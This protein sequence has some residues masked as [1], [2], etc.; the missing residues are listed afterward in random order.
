MSTL[1]DLFS[2]SLKKRSSAKAAK[3]ASEAVS[4]AEAAARRFTRF[5]A[6]RTENLKDQIAEK[7][8]QAVR[9]LPLLLHVNQEGLPGYMPDKLCPFGVT[10]FDPKEADLA[11]A[12]TLFPHS[13]LKRAAAPRMAVDLVSIMGSAGTIGFT[14][15]SDLDIW[16]CFRLD[17]HSAA[18]MALFD[19]KVR[20][21]EAWMNDYAGLETHLFLQ[22]T[23][24]IRQNDF[25]ETDLE[26]CGSAL[27]A[28]LKEEFYRT[29]I[30]LAGNFPFW[31]VV[32]P[33]ATPEEYSAK[34]HQL[35]ADGEFDSDGFVDLGPVEQVGLGELFGAAIWQIAKGQ[36]APFKSS[37]K[38]AYLEN[39][40]CSGTHQLPLCDILKELVARGEQPDPYRLLFDQV[41]KYYSDKGDVDAQELLA[42]CFY[43]KAGILL[44]PSLL[45]I[46]PHYKEESVILE[47]VKGWAWEPQKIERLNEFSSWKFELTRDLSARLN[48]FFMR[49][50]QRINEQLEL[51]GEKQT[52]TDR[53]LTVIGRK[54]QIAYRHAP[55]KVERVHMVI[56]SVQEP[57]LSLVEAPLSTGGTQWRLYSGRVNTINEEDYAH[58][59]IRFFNDPVEL[60]VWS[61]YN[62][63]LGDKTHLLCRPLQHRFSSAELETLALMLLEFM[64]RG[65]ESDQSVEALLDDPRPVQLTVVPN[66]GHDEE[67]IIDLCAVY[68]TSWGETFYQRFEGARALREFFKDLLIPFWANA[69][70]PGQVTVYAPGHGVRSLASPGHAP[71]ARLAKWTGELCASF[72]GAKLAH[73]VRRRHVMDSAEGFLLIERAGE[74]FEVKVCATHDQLLQKLCSVGPFDRVETTIDSGGGRLGKLALIEAAATRG[75]ID[76]FMVQ[77]RHRSEIYVHDEAGNLYHTLCEPGS[78][79]YALSKITIY[80]D[81]IF[82]ELCAQPTSPL[83]GV[84]RAQALKIHRLT[85][86]ALARALDATEEFTAKIKELGL[87]PRGLEIECSVDADGQ[88]LGYRINWGQEAISS[89]EVESPLEELKRRIDNDRR[90]TA[91]YGVYVTRLFLDNQFKKD[92]CGSYCATC[93]H[94]KYKEALERRLSS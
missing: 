65:E 47:Y 73:R 17:A 57:I 89:S 1:S 51:A 66:M 68:Q 87:N 78:E 81:N 94:L 34:V 18:A 25:G 53:D 23:E 75:R 74:L 28:M 40:V 80:I 9:L 3:A 30:I 72:G 16:I 14:T 85:Q 46:E 12:K 4:Q 90:S 55:H 70:D 20:L 42:E 93:H 19:E 41:L 54:L 91:R 88:P 37:L 8:H 29:A 49:S 27:G 5:N 77:D 35:R 83:F 26:G 52:I 32:E 2:R 45:E 92:H 10:G 22:A 84:A 43:L 24:H 64:D 69:P 59:L 7:A 13:A 36:R 56:A 15:S 79:I 6:E 38:M 76:L 44:N 31:C 11:L 86:G 39:T 50:Y 58:A 33:G 71:G 67:H 82:D 63:I 62:G 21:I 48:S 60:L 61:I